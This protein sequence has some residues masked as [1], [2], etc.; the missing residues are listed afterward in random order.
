MGGLSCLCNIGDENYYGDS[1]TI[2]ENPELCATLAEAF[3]DQISGCD[4]GI[5]VRDNQILPLLISPGA[6][7]YLP[8]LQ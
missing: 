6:A 8:H 3:E 2:E 4:L 1:I 5:A 7:F